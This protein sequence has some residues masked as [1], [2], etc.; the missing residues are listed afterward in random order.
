[1]K[2]EHKVLIVLGLSTIVIFAVLQA[3]RH[4]AIKN[5]FKEREEYCLLLGENLTFSLQ[6]NESYVEECSCTYQNIVSQEMEALCVCTCFTDGTV[7]P[8]INPV[9]RCYF[10]LFMSNNPPST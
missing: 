7:C 8:N 2:T 9:G 1:M 5:V 4:F 10:T 3:Y 6:A